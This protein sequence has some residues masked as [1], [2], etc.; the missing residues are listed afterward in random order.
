VAS[1]SDSQSQKIKA[2]PPDFLPIVTQRLVLRR[3]E[4]TDL[5]SFLAY[6]HDPEVAR[7]QSWSILSRDE[8]KTFIYEMQTEAMGVPGKWF[9]IAIATNPAAPLIG[10]IGLQ[11]DAQ[12][13]HCAEIGFTLDAQAQG[14]GYAQEAVRALLDRL[15]ELT[16]IEQVIGITDARNEPSIKLLKRLGMKQTRADSAVFKGERC[17][18]Y[19]FVLTKGAVL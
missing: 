12:N 3:F 2:F 9:Q 14:Q 15:F 10:D 1:S 5:D 6:R 7:Y 4:A 8:A 13:P 18:E 17:V 19:T 16:D 11:V